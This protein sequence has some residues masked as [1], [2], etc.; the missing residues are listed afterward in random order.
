M[1]AESSPLLAPLRKESLF[2]IAIILEILMHKN[3]FADQPYTREDIN[4]TLDSLSDYKLEWLTRLSK[5]IRTRK[6]Y[7]VRQNIFKISIERNPEP[8]ITI[9]LSNFLRINYYENFLKAFVELTDCK[10]HKIGSQHFTV[11]N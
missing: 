6:H 5:K 9:Q 8:V 7:W 3:G 10:L 2:L 4:D 11:S 1:S